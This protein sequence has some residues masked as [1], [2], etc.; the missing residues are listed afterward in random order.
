MV[1]IRFGIFIAAAIAAFSTQAIGQDLK[2]AGL[3]ADGN[4]ARATVLQTTLSP[5]GWADFCQRHA[6]DCDGAISNPVEIR[7]SRK[8]WRDLAAVNN[9]FNN[10]IIP[11]TDMEH[12][13][14]EEKWDF[15]SDGK[16]DCEDYVL[17]KRRMLVDMGYPRQA[18]LVTVVRDNLGEGHAV[19][20]VTTDRGDIVL[21]NRRKEI[22]SW[23]RTGYAYI[24]RQ[25]GVSQNIWVSL[26]E[27]Q[28][29]LA[30]ASR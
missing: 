14:V 11:V 5:M 7:L 20:T 3:P 21:D 27:P 26:G 18:L 29:Q 8:A 9:H 24:K 17:A 10:T 4:L 15:P 28:S 19:L 1:S 23:T 30:T 25:S 12:W 16:G 6:E 13:G 2:T 22:L